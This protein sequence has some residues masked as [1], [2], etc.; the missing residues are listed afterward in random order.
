MVVGVKHWCRLPRQTVEPPFLVIFKTQLD[1]VLINLILLTCFEQGV[2][3]DDPQQ[4]LP[5]STIP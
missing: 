3:L 5:T 4:S 2:G 1:N